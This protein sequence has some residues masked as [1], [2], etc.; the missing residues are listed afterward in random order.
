MGGRAH[1]GE[2]VTFIVLHSEPQLWTVGSYV[3][4]PPGP[5]VTAGQRFEP[6]SDHDSQGEAVEY[7]A[8]M[9]GGPL[10]V[11]EVAARADAQREAAR[12]IAEE[13]DRRSLA[14][15]ER[16]ADALERMAKMQERATVALERMQDHAQ[17]GPGW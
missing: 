11:S 9:N 10:P 2:A 8:W 3:P 6:V 12:A 17:F 15:L 13:A 14:A 16:V 5:G 7:A 4:A 1:R